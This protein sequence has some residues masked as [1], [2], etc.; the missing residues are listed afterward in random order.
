MLSGNNSWQLLKRVGDADEPRSAP[1]LAEAS[2]REGAVVKSAAHAEPHAMGVETHERHE[3]Q[4]QP[5]RADGARRL[6]LADPQTI[7]ALAAGGFDEAHLAAVSRA[8][9]PRHVDAPT[10]ATR[11]REEGSAVEFVAQ[12]AL[13]GDAISCAQSEAAIDVAR[14]ELRG[15]GAF[16]GRE[17]AA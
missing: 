9:D 17:C 11:Q 2:I 10:A 13:Q 4:I 1:C 8:L 12:R 7:H 16:G 14:D 5:A 3:H 6:R 15:A